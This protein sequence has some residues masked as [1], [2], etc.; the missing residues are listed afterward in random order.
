MMMNDAVTTRRGWWRRNALPLV[1]VAVLL[2]ATFGMVGWNEW[3]DYFSGRPTQP[4]VASAGASV[5]FEDAIW[6]PAEIEIMEPGAEFEAPADSQVVM[7]AVPVDPGADAATCLAPTLRENT[8]ARR[9]WQHVTFEIGWSPSSDQLGSCALTGTDPF[10]MTV[11]FLV[12]LDAA[13]PFAVD[14]V[15]PDAL[16]RFVRLL[17]EP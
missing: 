10:T 11:A 12:P 14:F 5:E 2:P 6:G 3:N 4:V 9:E 7:V 8:G 1:G 15:S 16:P 13:G 17:V